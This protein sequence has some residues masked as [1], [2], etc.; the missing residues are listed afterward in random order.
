MKIP[1]QKYSRDLR[2][3]YR[4]PSVQV[5]LTLVLSLF[6]MAAFIAF[7][8][9]P[10][11]VAIGSLR[12]DIV[13]ARDTLTKLDN[14]VT[15]LQR[16]STQLD[17][18]KSF[19]PIL[20]T[21]IPNNGAMYSPLTTSIELIARQTGTVLESET[22]GST[23]L[24]SRILAPFTPSKNQSVVELPFSVRVAGSYPAVTTFLNQLLKMERI[25][26]VESVTITKE[27]VTKTE[28][29]TVALNVNGSAYY[30]ADEAQLLKAMPKGNK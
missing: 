3:Y 22:L 26:M 12:A 20:N 23:L 14:K 25:I 19:L 29:D 24:F 2:R 13:E 7:A 1:T 28:T 27:A 10:T 8:L 6:V 11:I 17:A 4:M 21:S 16:A 9:R 15:N 5:S 30:L 18:A